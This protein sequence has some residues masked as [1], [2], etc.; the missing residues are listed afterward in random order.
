VPVARA[1]SVILPPP[2]PAPVASA[3][4]PIIEDAGGDFRSF[5][6]GLVKIPLKIVLAPQQSLSATGW[7]LLSYLSMLGAEPLHD[8]SVAVADVQAY[9]GGRITAAQVRE[10]FRLLTEDKFEF[11]NGRR[12]VVHATGNSVHTLTFYLAEE[13]YLP[14]GNDKEEMRRFPYAL[15]DLRCIRKFK[16][17]SNLRLYMAIAYQSRAKNNTRLLTPEDACHL[18]GAPDG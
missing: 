9:L 18:F 1:P 7:K 12:A 8:V 6:G 14:R 5:G 11:D 10:E 3:R 17:V 13:T 2:A 15:V 16:K 4:M